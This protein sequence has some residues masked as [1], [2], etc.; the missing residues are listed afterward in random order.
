MET[1]RLKNIAILILLLLNAF[2]L[3]LL[4]YQY[5]QSRQT[6]SDTVEQLHTIALT[7]H[8]GPGTTVRILLPIRQE[9][10]E[11]GEHE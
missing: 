7:D 2:L 11:E 5:L 8:D 10:C 9:G 6:A 4:G 3:M 1:Y